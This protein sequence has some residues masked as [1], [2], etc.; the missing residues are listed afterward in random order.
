LYN[1]IQS[2][3]R[4]SGSLSLS[5]IE[6]GVH[7]LLFDMSF[8]LA[9]CTGHFAATGCIS[10]DAAADTGG[11]VAV[12]VAGAADI[13]GNKSGLVCTVPA[14][15]PDCST[16]MQPTGQG[17]EISM[18]SHSGTTVLFQD[19]NI[20]CVDFCHNPAGD[21]GCSGNGG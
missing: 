5:S 13:C 10:A 14:P 2:W 1:L 9:C 3:C 7:L 6:T 8:S 17:R 15:Y 18:N 20:A 12:S 19:K 11:V 21:H 16:S 4:I